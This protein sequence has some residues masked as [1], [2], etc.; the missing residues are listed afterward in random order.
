MIN[1]TRLN[2]NPFVL[3]AE[4]IREIEATPD[5]IITLTTGQKIMVQQ[6]VDAVMSMV[7]EYK[8]FVAGRPPHGKENSD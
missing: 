2:G 5:T 7:I 3:N 6:P 8:R 1:L 4:M